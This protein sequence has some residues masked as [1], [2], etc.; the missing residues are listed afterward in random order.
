MSDL[1][2][3]HRSHFQASFILHLRNASLQY[4]LFLDLTYDTMWSL[5]YSYLKIV[6]ESILQSRDS[7]LVMYEQFIEQNKTI[8]NL[9]TKLEAIHEIMV[10]IDESRML[11]LFYIYSAY[12][13]F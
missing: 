7:Y 12:C 13:N 8:T 11:C 6:Y 4:D 9:Q 10:R 3:H 5:D 1:N 2:Y